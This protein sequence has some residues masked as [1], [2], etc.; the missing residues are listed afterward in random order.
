MRVSA[1]AG[2]AVLEVGTVAGFRERQT[3]TIGSD[4]NAESATIASTNFWGGASITLAAP[5]KLQHAKGDAVSGSGIT[6]AKALAQAHAAG[7]SVADNVPTPGAPN[8]YGN[9]TE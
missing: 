6:L 3:I 9:G 7:A 4:A 5:L 1:E 8:Q 2:A